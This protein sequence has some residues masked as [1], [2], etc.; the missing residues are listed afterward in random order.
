MATK[1]CDQTKD[2]TQLIDIAFSVV[3]AV[4]TVVALFNFYLLKKQGKYE[5]RNFRETDLRI[6]LNETVYQKT[7]KK[8]LQEP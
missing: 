4:F 2:T 7:A 1:H 8:H 6:I 3:L 5:C